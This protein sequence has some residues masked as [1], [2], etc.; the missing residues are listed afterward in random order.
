MSLLQGRNGTMNCSFSEAGLGAE[1][2][3]YSVDEAHISAALSLV[4]PIQLA[5]DS[6]RSVL[7]L[8]CSVTV[9]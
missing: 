1:H 8:K 3:A 4:Q 6:A 7:G 5:L 9:R 2:V